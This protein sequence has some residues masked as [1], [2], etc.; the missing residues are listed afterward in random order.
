MLLLLLFVFRMNIT[1]PPCLLN[2]EQGES[3]SRISHK[4]VRKSTLTVTDVAESVIKS[5][6]EGLKTA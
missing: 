5:C 1:H 2:F 3:V 6:L 4:I